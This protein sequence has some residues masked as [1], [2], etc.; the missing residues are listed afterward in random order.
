[1]SAPPPTHLY[2]VGYR[3]CGKSTVG[4][5]LAR[6]WDWPLIDTDALV[7]E[8]DGR[9]IATIFAEDGESTFRDLETAAIESIQNH[10][11]SVIALGGG[12]V[13]RPTNVDW[14]G[15][16][17]CV[18]L[19]ASATTLAA[20][21]ASDAATGAQRPPL[22]GRGVIDEI[23]EVLQIREPIY[24]RIADQTIQVDGLSPGGVADRITQF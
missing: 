17:R 15:R 18:Y 2:L 1:M 22:T 8:A 12:V 7:V 20:R 6:R 9:D 4:R 24:R 13:L 23:S 10:P 11:A 21:I 16:G 19:A 5:L 3:G 14:I